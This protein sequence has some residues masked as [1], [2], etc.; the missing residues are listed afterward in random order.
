[1]LIIN[2]EILKQANE[3]RMKIERVFIQAVIFENEIY[4]TI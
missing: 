2:V 4:K 1:M 3:M